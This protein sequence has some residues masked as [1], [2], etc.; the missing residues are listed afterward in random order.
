MNKF[1]YVVT[2]NEPNAREALQRRTMQKEV[3]QR[4]GRRERREIKAGWRRTP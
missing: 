4:E 1:A 3:S 2:P